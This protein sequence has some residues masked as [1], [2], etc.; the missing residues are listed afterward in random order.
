MKKLLSFGVV[1]AS[2]LIASCGGGGD[3]TLARPGGGTATVA[4]VELLA[5]SPQILSDLARNNAVTLTAVVKDA[6]N[7]ILADVP[8]TFSADSGSLT[9]IRGT[10]DESGT[11][12]ASLTNG[13][14]VTNRSITVNARA[15]GVTGTVTVNVTG[16]T[17]TVT[18]ASA[19]L[20][21]GASSAFSV[22]VKD[23]LGAGVAD[24]EVEISSSN[25][26]TLSASSLTTGASG[27]ASFDLTADQSGEDTVTV[28]A[29]GITREAS[30]TVSGD[31]FVFTAPAQNAEI[32]LGNDRTVTVRWRVDGNPVA[33]GTS[34]GFSST[35]GTLSASSALTVNGEASVTVTSDNAGPA[36]ITAT[37]PGGLSVSRQVEFVATNADTLDLQAEP[38]TVRSGEQ[39]TITAIVRDPDGNL[40]KN[41]V[42][43]FELTDITNGFLSVASATTDS[44]GRAVTLY[45]GG[46]VTS[47]VDG[48]SIRAFVQSEPAVEDTVQ[49][50]VAG[51]ALAISLG[52]GNALFEIGTATF[53]KEWAIF[54]TDAD[55]NPVDNKTVQVAIRSVNYKKGQL[56]VVSVGGDEVWAKVT[57]AVCADEDVNLNGILDGGEDL[58][59]S[60]SIEAGNIATVAAVPADASADEPCSDAG[61]QGQS[62]TVVTNGIGQARV[63]VF[64]AQS[65]NLWLDARISAKASVQGT[66]Y[67]KSQTFELEALA[68]DINNTNASPPG[69]T[70]PFGP[71]PD[72]S[73]APPP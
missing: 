30:V 53:A 41:K 39:S 31:D 12:A 58:N 18:P 5:S 1:L 14:D 4:T 17:V 57:E 61:S 51:Q 37:A 62:A 47:P 28:T 50:T 63:C 15:S 9:V 71:E 38:F 44:Q 34:I 46:S 6:D 29:L 16:T 68:A 22:L 10:T 52:T 42:V 2:A 43:S 54:V 26:N 56:G 65:Y 8:V 66:E 21:L 33:D 24:V 69:V 64:Y 40:V 19:S 60:G 67:S 25:G 70:S 23:S 13:P 73:I 55:G 48:V 3:D 11:A 72:C 27:D 35:R 59:S 7:A 45:T 49:L 36:V 32:P 20:G